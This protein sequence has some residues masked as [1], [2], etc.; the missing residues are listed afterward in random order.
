MKL[1][2]SEAKTVLTSRIDPQLK[3]QL[4]AEA[5]AKNATLSNHVEQ[6]LF[7]RSDPSTDVYELKNRLFQLEAENLDLRQKLQQG[8]GV[9]PPEIADLENQVRLLKRQNLELQQAAQQGFRQREALLRQHVEALPHWISADAH[10]AVLRLLGDLRKKF[11]KRD[12]E[13]LLLASL[14]TALQNTRSIFISTL[15]DFFARHPNFSTQ[16][17]IERCEK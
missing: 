7:R 8:G 12:F 14:A 17:F 2:F 4:E 11:P 9:P 3:E 15:A 16:K 6:L 13:H 5:T 1:I 10:R